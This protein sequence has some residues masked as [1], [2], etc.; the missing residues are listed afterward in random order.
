MKTRSIG[1]LMAE[2]FFVLL[3][4][5]AAFSLDSW[6]DG[7]QARQR[8]LS[9]LRVMRGEFASSREMLEQLTR[10]HEAWSHDLE[11]LDGF[12]SAAPNLV[13][14]DS[15]L[16]LSQALWRF[17]DYDPAMPTYDELLRTSGLQSISD[18]EL[19]TAFFRYE[20]ALRRNRDIDE[21]IRGSAMAS[22]EPLLADLIPEMDEQ[23]L[24]DPRGRLMAP[25]AALSMNLAFRNLIAERKELEDELVLQRGRLEG[26]VDE[27]LDLIDR[28][29][30]AET[31]SKSD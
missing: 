18:D 4:I 27:V 5:L 11:R 8:E 21:W 17:S 26:A 1:H 12:L 25:V 14:K 23:P 3:G 2:G 22:W 13:P 29:L 20:L 6:W 31:E 24:S 10:K 28:E 15:V 16:K 7:H 9:Y 19:R 30:G